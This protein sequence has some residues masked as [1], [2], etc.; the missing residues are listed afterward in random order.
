MKL[1]LMHWSFQISENI[2]EKKEE[3]RNLQEI[4]KK[5]Y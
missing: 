5:N 2:K 4:Y 1:A 3:T